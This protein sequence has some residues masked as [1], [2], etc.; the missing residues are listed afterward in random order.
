MRLKSEADWLTKLGNCIFV[1]AEN[2]F[3]QE[4]GLFLSIFQYEN[5]SLSRYGS[6]GRRKY[7]LF[8]EAY[9][10]R[11]L[12]L[13]LILLIACIR[14]SVSYSS[15][16]QNSSTCLFASPL[17]LPVAISKTGFKLL[18]DTGVVF[19]APTCDS[20]CTWTTFLMVLPSRSSCASR[21]KS[22]SEI[23]CSGHAFFTSHRQMPSFSPDVRASYSM[24]T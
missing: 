6:L 14:S 4:Q 5:K 3:L 18:K 24:D 15:S 13:L 11:E 21:L 23:A 17:T 9:S 10:N 12:V 16:R 22:A 19:P 7:A 20:R 1:L 8:Q 2:G